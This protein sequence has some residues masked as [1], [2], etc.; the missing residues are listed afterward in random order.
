MTINER[1]EE[2]TIDE[3]LY[4][5]FGNKVE[6][7]V[8]TTLFRQGDSCQQYVFIKSGGV[9]VFTRSENGRELVLYRIKPNESCTLT[10]SCLLGDAFYPAEAVTESDVV[11]YV[12]SKPAFLSELNRSSQFRAA[13]FNSYAQ[14]LKDVIS[15]ISE[16]NFSRIDA[17]LAK[18][19]LTQ[20]ENNQLNITHQQLATELGSA[21]EVV[22]RH[23]K[24][25]EKRGW[26]RLSRGI[27]V[28]DDKEALRALG[29]FHLI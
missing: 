26:V 18:F 21:R 29:E 4:Q 5:L 28:L 12:L 24:E 6:I 16:V 7:P 15:L 14:R 2:Q 8:G 23:L 13:I 25:F 9:K 27:I 19:L 1:N 22:S 17:R 3:L 20:C 11:A 10:T